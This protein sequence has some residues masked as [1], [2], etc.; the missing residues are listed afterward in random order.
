MT[1][2]IFGG[3]C[4]L[5]GIFTAWVWLT[6]FSPFAQKQDAK[7]HGVKV[8]CTHCG[9]MYRTGYNNVRTANYCNECR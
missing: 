6:E 4:F 3:I 8:H 1:Y 2:A 9:R 5:I 7:E